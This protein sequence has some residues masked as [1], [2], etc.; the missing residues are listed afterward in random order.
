MVKNGNVTP[1]EL[2]FTLIVSNYHNFVPMELYVD[3]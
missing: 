1:T 3:F 2:R